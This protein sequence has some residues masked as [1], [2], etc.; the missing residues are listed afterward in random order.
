MDKTYKI[1][2]TGKY[3]TLIISIILLLLFSFACISIF[4][5]LISNGTIQ[6]E[7]I[8]FEF[9]FPSFLLLI[10]VLTFVVGK[11]SYF[12]DEVM[13]TKNCFKSKK[14]GVVNFEEI[15]SYNEFKVRGSTVFLVKFHIRKKMAIGPY[16]NFSVKADKIFIEFISAFEAKY[17][18][19]NLTKK[20]PNYFIS[21]ESKNQVK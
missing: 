20:E 5:F 14:L 18:W 13:I 1:S 15:V 10:G 11:R 4:I 6:K 3:N 9:A 2:I 19:Y 8:R 21:D 7:S 12:V 17:D 16:S